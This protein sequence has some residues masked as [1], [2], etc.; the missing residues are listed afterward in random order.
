MHNVTTMCIQREMFQKAD[1]YKVKMFQ[2]EEGS[3]FNKG[4]LYVPS[5]SSKIKERIYMNNSYSVKTVTKFLLQNM[6]TLS[7]YVLCLVL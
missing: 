7:M 4:T 5:V 6:Y 1:P 3:S 2:E